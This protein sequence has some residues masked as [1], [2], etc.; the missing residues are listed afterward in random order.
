MK[1][2]INVEVVLEYP[3]L[4]QKWLL[5]F[6]GEYKHTLTNILSLNSAH[7]SLHTLHEVFLHIYMLV[8]S[9]ML[10]KHFSSFSSTTLIA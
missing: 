1:H 6:V 2:E 4:I 9:K 10:F 7:V 3:F 5:D 8:P